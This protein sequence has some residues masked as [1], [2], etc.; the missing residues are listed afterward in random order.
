MERGRERDF[1]AVK[2]LIVA[3]KFF[4]SMPAR[5]FPSNMHLCSLNSYILSAENKLGQEC[6]I[7]ERK[8]LTAQEWHPFLETQIGKSVSNPFG[9]FV[10]NV[11]CEL[12][13]A[14][15]TLHVQH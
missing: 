10:V 6:D 7:D 8:D 5:M 12:V 15:C 11:A 2:K 14:F 1:L 13:C 9:L 3:D 4:P